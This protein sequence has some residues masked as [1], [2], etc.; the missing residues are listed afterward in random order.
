MGLAPLRGN[1]LT[2]YS[3]ARERSNVNHVDPPACVVGGCR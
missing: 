1:R 3:A 2:G